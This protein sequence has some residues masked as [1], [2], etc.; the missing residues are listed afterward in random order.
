VLVATADEPQLTPRAEE[1]L[2]NLGSAVGRA[3]TVWI[4]KFAAGRIAVRTHSLF[5]PDESI[6]RAEVRG[7]LAVVYRPLRRDELVASGR[8]R[9]QILVL[10]VMPARELAT[11]AEA[12]QRQ[13]DAIA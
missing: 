9:P 11:E 2:K 4:A 8:V 1:D 5:L 12:L 13:I 7:G 10:R 3:M 6:K